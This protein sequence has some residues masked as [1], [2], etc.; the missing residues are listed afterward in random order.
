MLTTILTAAALIFPNPIA[1]TSAIDAESASECADAC[2]QYLEEDSAALRCD[3]QCLDEHTGF[4][5]ETPPVDAPDWMPASADT[6]S[7]PTDHD[8]CLQTCD[9][10]SKSATDRE[11]C[12]LNC[13]VSWSVLTTTPDVCEGPDADEHPELC[14]SE[15]ASACER[16]CFVNAV[17]CRESCEDLEGTRATDVASCELR[18]ENLAELCDSS[19]ASEDPD[20]FTSTDRE[21]DAAR[22]PGC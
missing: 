3:I 13:A 16:G 17:T 8:W 4:E 11:T 19:C 21:Y 15:A 20:A 6:P 10:E 9:D 2:F 14:A 7:S 18:C 22:E 12:R 5:F 1:T